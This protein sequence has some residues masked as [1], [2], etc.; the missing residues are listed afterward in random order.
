MGLFHIAI[1][2]VVYGVWKLP[3]IRRRPCLYILSMYFLLV[4]GPIHPSF[5]HLSPCLQEIIFIYRLVILQYTETSLTETGPGTLTSKGAKAAFY[6]LQSAIELFV[7]AFLLLS[8]MRQLYGVGR[9]GDRPNDRQLNKKLQEKEEERLA[10][11]AHL[12][13]AIQEGVP[14]S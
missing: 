5:Y 6:L 9:F 13:P 3:R 8:P 14:S 10:S 2:W 11:T 1:G 12:T 4:R 7:A